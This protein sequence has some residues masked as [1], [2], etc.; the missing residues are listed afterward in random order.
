MVKINTKS[1]DKELEYLRQRVAELE[2]AEDRYR[3]LM[4]LGTKIGEAVIMLQDI[5]GKEGVQTHVSDQWPKITGY[6][7]KELLG[8]P[9]F[10]LVSVRDKESS[11]QRHRKKMAGEAVPDLFELTVINKNGKEVPIEITSGVVSYK[12][13]LT[14]AVYIRDITE[15]KRAEKLIDMEGDRYTQL[16]QYAPIAVW[17]VDYSHGMP[18]I[19][20]LKEEGVT[21]FDNYFRKHPESFSNFIT[22]ARIIY[23]NKAAR[24]IIN[25][26]RVDRTD[27]GKLNELL[28]RFVNNEANYLERNY[29]KGLIK[30]WSKIVSGKTTRIIR[31]HLDPTKTGR[32]KYVRACISVRPGHEHDLS[33]VY[34]IS[35]D[36]TKQINAERELRKYHK[37]LESL[38]EDRTSQL[39]E[40]RQ[41]EH[42]LLQSEKEIR[43]KLEV[44]LENRLFFTRALVHELKTPL[45]PIL[46]ASE[47]LEKNETDKTFKGIARTINE[48]TEA[49]SR[50]VDELLDISRGETGLLK[51]N[52]KRSDIVQLVDDTYKHM[53]FIFGKKNQRFMLDIP[54]NMPKMKIDKKMIQQV[55]VN[56][57]DNA[58][59]FTPRD[60]TIILRLRKNGNSAEFEVE[61][62]GAGIGF[63]EQENI[64]EYYHSVR[65]RH[66]PNSGVGLGLSLSKMFVELHGGK[67]WVQS[68]KGKGSIFTFSLPYGEYI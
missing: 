17:E 64:F 8:I 19:S 22:S 62:T 14:N 49:L 50:R 36:I 2:G 40:S 3:T 12:G 63:N 25:S 38:V 1:K 30:D 54:N 42:K 41:R 4:E 11:I 5:G 65:S 27:I 10:D 16:L 7:R 29:I 46:L 26:K 20:S 39:E 45:T 60:G 24:E 56:L 21:N 35:V 47:L 66:S 34:C 57:L 9:F 58:S 23:C 28:K 59:K 44:Q 48:G 52:P 33:R 68:E 32:F 55:L 37:H 53:S 15:R 13:E 51:I 43:E 6:S 31:D 61:D 18:L 67:I